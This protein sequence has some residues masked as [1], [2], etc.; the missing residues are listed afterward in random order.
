M[1][2]EFIYQRDT[3][4]STGEEAS[5]EEDERRREVNYDHLKDALQ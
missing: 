2:K 5:E 3:E 4:L 1:M